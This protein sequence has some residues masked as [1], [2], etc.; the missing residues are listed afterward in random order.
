MGNRTKQ[1]LGILM[2]I[3]GACGPCWG[4][5]TGGV[6]FN[7]TAPA[8]DLALPLR[9]TGVLNYMVF[10]KAYAAALYLPKDVDPEK[11]L[12]AAPKRLEIEYFHRISAPDFA[13]ATSE[14]IRRNRSPA[15]FERLKPQI[16]AFNALYRDVAPGDRYALS[17]VPDL[18]TTLSWNGQPLGTAHGEEIAA[19]LFGI[20][21]GPSPLDRGLRQR[22][23]GQK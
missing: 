16:D 19:A 22:L 2:L 15:L 1:T 23:L 12:G 5:D 20:W 9:G 11:I 21:L 6:I 3:L 18:G 14:S 7:D 8:G 4:T 13:A 17:Y 10:I